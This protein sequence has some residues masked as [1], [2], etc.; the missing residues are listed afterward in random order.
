MPF[1]RA[2]STPAT[3]SSD[4]A[5]QQSRPE[6]AGRFRH[7]P[8]SSIRAFR[9][10]AR[11]PRML[12]AKPRPTGGA[13]R[14]RE[15]RRSAT[16]TCT[17]RRS[18]S[19]NSTITAARAGSIR[20]SATSSFRRTHER[21]EEVIGKPQNALKFLMMTDGG[22]PRY[23]RHPAAGADR[24]PAVEL[25]DQVPRRRDHGRRGLL[26]AAGDAAADSGRAALLRRHDL[27]GQEG[28]Q[29]RADGRA[30]RSRRSAPPSPRICSRASP[31]SASRSTAST[32]SPST[33]TPTTRCSSAPDRSASGCA[34]RTATTSGSARNRRSRRSRCARA[35]GVSPN[36]RRGWYAGFSPS[37]GRRLAVGWLPA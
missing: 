13:P 6:A 20:R 37:T 10:P 22:L 29:H 7:R 14:D 15:P 28:V 19:R 12:A 23:P 25:R 26:G 16:S 32:G 2:Y 4:P 24:G 5:D 8:H 9:A 3:P 11:P 17:A 34:S 1:H 35:A 33:P 18:P 27:G 31:P 21:T 36:S 30:R